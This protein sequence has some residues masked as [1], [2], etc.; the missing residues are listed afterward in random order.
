MSTL[1]VGTISEKVT[2]AGV[3]VDGVTLKDGGAVFTSAVT[4]TDNTVDLGASSTRFKD[5]Y[6]SGGAYIG[7]TGSANYLDDYEEGSFTAT[8]TPNTSGTITLDS[9]KDILQYTK[10][11]RLVTINGFLR[12]NSVSSPV[13]D[14][15]AIETLPFVIG[16]FDELSGR[17][18][19][20]IMMKDASVSGAN[21]YEMEGAI[22]IETETKIRVYRDASTLATTDDIYVG[23][24]Y[25]T[26][27]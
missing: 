1:T 4:A 19:G 9:A 22:L 25:V 27:A 16:D 8:C 21:A 3:A 5:L 24:T 23:C 6:L 20:G 13:G 15:F 18:Q 14:Y 12:I 2:D 10:V 26:T 11:G 7:G 17:T